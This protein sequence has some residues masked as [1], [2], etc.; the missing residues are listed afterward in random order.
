MLSFNNFILIFFTM[1]N[2]IAMFNAKTKSKCP[3]YNDIDKG[4]IFPTP[5]LS[6]AVAYEAEEE[7]QVQQR[8]R[9]HNGGVGGLVRGTSKGS[10]R[11]HSHRPSHHSS[12][13]HHHNH[14]NCNECESSD[15][16]CCK[17]GPTGPRGCDGQDGDRGER[18]ATG[19]TGPTGRGATG[20]TGCTGPTGCGITGATGV[21]GPTGPKGYGI[22]CLNIEYI[23][24]VVNCV[25]KL[26]K[27]CKK[28]KYCLDTYDGYVYY[29]DVCKHKW[30]KIDPQPCLPFYFYDRKCLDIWHIN[31]CRSANMYHHKSGQVFDTIHRDIYCYHDGWLPCCNLTGRDGC[32]G[33][34]GKRGATGPAGPTGGRGTQIYTLSIYYCG[35][36]SETRHL[37]CVVGDFLGQLLLAEDTAELYEW[38]SLGWRVYEEP[39]TY[40]YFYAIKDFNIFYVCPE[41]DT[42]ELYLAHEGDILLDD[43]SCVLFKFHSNKWHKLCC[44]KGPKGATGDKGATGAT[45]AT[46]PT[47]AKG[48]EG[49]QGPRGPP[50]RD[51]KPFKADNCCDLCCNDSTSCTEDDCFNCICF[52]NPINKH[53]HNNNIRGPIPQRIQDVSI[54]SITDATDTD[55]EFS[56]DQTLSAPKFTNYNWLNFETTDHGFNMMNF[57]EINEYKKETK[58]QLVLALK[59]P[60]CLAKK[61]F[62]INIGLEE[63]DCDNIKDVA[64]T[65]LYAT[66]VKGVNVNL[67][68]NAKVITI[69]VNKNFDRYV[70]VKLDA[71]CKPKYNYN[72][73]T[74]SFTSEDVDMDADNVLKVLSLKL[75]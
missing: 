36:V 38:S 26:K 58:L 53:G 13:N 50:G 73:W 25:D 48:Q 4:N 45:G 9:K 19:P 18:G 39:K 11:H 15:D 7:Y 67:S 27:K 6:S 32:E 62:Q 41:Q 49:V 40:F 30:R 70:I 21:T 54:D 65:S 28:S 43:V 8:Y 20:H 74:W 63:Q 64:F 23:G 22:E 47:G 3:T 16:R 17:K 52:K 75:A 24:I 61:C 42:I 29:Y 33:P 68:F 34:T 66:E 5:P 46:G 51:C 44:L 35:L 60:T 1:I 57:Y 59:N 55:T 56:E 72:L 12:N 10:G 71:K 69:D 37:H 31:D 14:D 2:I